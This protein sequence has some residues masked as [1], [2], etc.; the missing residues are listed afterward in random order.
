MSK[1]GGD[2]LKEACITVLGSGHLRPMPGTWGSAASVVIYVPLWYALHISN[3]PRW[4]IDLVAVVGILIAS[5]LSGLWGQWAIDKFGRKDPR[6]FVLDEFAGQWVSLLWLPALAATGLWPFMCVVGGQFVLFRIMDV[7]KPPPAR[8][9]ESLPAGWGILC[10]DLMAG[11]YALIVG[12]L[13]WRLTP[14][15][16]WL[17]FEIS[18]QIAAL[19]SKL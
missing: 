12:Q 13:V 8:Q 9:L 16:D 6:Q 3:A 14:L 11:V 10:D 7:F 15:A 19:A 1:R 18:P 17:G 5:W 2:W 4:G